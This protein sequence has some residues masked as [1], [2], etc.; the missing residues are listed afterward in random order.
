MSGNNEGN[1]ERHEGDFTSEPRDLDSPPTPSDTSMPDVPSSDWR[2]R[3]FRVEKPKHKDESKRNAE[4]I[5]SRFV[6]QS[7][8]PNTTSGHRKSK[9]KDKKSLDSVSSHILTLPG[10]YSNSAFYADIDYQDPHVTKMSINT[11]DAFG[12]L[13]DLIQ[14]I[15]QGSFRFVLLSRVDFDSLLPSWKIHIG[16]ADKGRWW[17]G[18]WEEGDVDAFVGKNVSGDLL[19]AFADNIA[20]TVTQGELFVGDIE[21]GAQPGMVVKMIFGPNGTRPLAIP[22][23]EMTQEDAAIFVINEF[24]ILGLSAQ[25]RKCKLNP[26]TFPS[27]SSAPKPVATGRGPEDQLRPRHSPPS[28]PVKRKVSI[29][30]PTRPPQNLHLLGPEQDSS[31]PRKIETEM[32]PG[33]T[34][35]SLPKA[36]TSNTNA[37]L[38]PQVV[39]VKKKA[40]KVQRMEFASDEE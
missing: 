11:F 33:P 17:Q 23:N 32:T 10:S 3:K 21:A 8:T 15:Y 28:T 40:R 4:E 1:V 38:K 5:A 9:S 30:P 14:V 12:P 37:K 13:D 19:E 35:A 7:S 36:E 6:S 24:F 29:S 20:K 18:K 27:Y 26:P 25:K 22:L 16:L 2:T 34:L 31:P 39:P